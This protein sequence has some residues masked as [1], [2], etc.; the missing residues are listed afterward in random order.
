M[1]GPCDALYNSVTT[2]TK[3]WQSGGLRA[4][5]TE[6]HQYFCHFRDSGCLDNHC[7]NRTL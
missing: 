6:K 7:R 2:V 4:V 3:R 1:H 5:E